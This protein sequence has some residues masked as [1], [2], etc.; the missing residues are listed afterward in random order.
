MEHSFLLIKPDAYNRGLANDVRKDILMGCR[1]RDLSIIL[2]KTK[3]LT[4]DEVLKIYPAIFEKSFP[5]EFIELMT[6]NLSTLVLVAGKD[7][8]IKTKTI[9]GYYKFKE[10]EETRGIR[11]KYC[12]VECVSMREAERLKRNGDPQAKQLI[13]VII[14]GI[15]H[16]PDT[17]DEVSVI[18]EIF[19]C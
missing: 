17:P 4:T 12:Y 1:E 6:S 7:A 9:R 19:G 10:E 11:G 5:Y 8:I 13:A 18:S 2:E 15:V 14:E 16:A 3:T